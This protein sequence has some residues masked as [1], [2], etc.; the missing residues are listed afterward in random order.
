VDR[1]EVSSIPGAERWSYGAFAHAEGGDPIIVPLLREDGASAEFTVPDF[2]NDPEDLRQI[3]LIV[4]GAL[5][6]WDKVK[7]LGG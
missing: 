2:V 5:E 4:I 7:G 6:K 1:Q 3:A